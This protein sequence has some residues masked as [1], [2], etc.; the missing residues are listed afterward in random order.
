MRDYK[1]R[2]RVLI[3]ILTVALLSICHNAKP[4][5][6]VYDF[7]SY[8]DGYNTSGTIKKRQP[9]TFRGEELKPY[10]DNAPTWV[11]M[12]ESSVAISGAIQ[13]SKDSMRQRNS[14]QL[15]LYN[16]MRANGYSHGQAIAV[17]S[18]QARLEDVGPPQ[19]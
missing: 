1:S 15:E 5:D 2:N 9:V 12:F 14:E 13:E 6:E 4:Q 18:G 17:S 7:E 11:K 3:V 10:R 19:Q 16:M 8:N